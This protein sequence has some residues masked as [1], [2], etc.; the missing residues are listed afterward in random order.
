MK[1]ESPN[2]LN[3]ENENIEADDYE[4]EQNLLGFFQLLLKVDMRVNPNLYKKKG[5]KEQKKGTEK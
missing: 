5:I 3:R 2:E 1:A 4:A